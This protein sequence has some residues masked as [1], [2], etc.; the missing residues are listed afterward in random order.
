MSPRE[1]LTGGK[2]SKE[3]VPWRLAR[4][5]L[6]NTDGRRIASLE[7]E[8][9]GRGGTSTSL[10]ETQSLLLHR[11]DRAQA[12]TGVSDWSSSSKETYS[13]DQSLAGFRQTPLQFN[14]SS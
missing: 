2:L 6:W 1:T 10:V 13:C 8:H 14:E 5:M 11:K 4:D 7:L 9:W 3:A 12:P